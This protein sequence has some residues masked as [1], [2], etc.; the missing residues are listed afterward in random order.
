MCYPGGMKA[1]K[2]CAVDRASWY[3]DTH[4]LKPGTVPIL[5]LPTT[6]AHR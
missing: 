3:N 2:P 4:V 5:L 6:A 1:H